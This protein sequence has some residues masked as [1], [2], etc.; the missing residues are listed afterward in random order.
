MANQ[1]SAKDEGPAARVGQVIK[2]KWK[3]EGLLGVGGMAAVYAAAHRNGQRAALKILH[4]DFAREKTIC[5]RFLREAYVSNKVNH[6]A[7]VHVLDDDTTE[8]GEPFLI[9]ELLEG[10]TVR[11]AWKKSGRTMPVGRVLQ[12]CERVLD[13][14]A[15]CL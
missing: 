4:A 9:M 10:E 15:S 11:D 3:V 13:C 12:I 14:L 2:G 1:K 7:T 5:D 8:Q 6:S